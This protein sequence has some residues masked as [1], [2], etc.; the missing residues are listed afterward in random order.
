MS[1]PS[2]VELW[3]YL[4]GS[5]KLALSIPLDECRTF[6]L[7]PLKW[8]R[9]LGFVIYGRQGYISMSTNG[10][11]REVDPYTPRFFLTLLTFLG[12][13][14]F[15]DVDAI[16]NKTRS[17]STSEPSTRKRGFRQ[18][19]ISRDGTCAMIGVDAPFCE[20]CHLIPRSKGDS[21]M[22]NLFDHRGEMYGPV[23]PLDDIDD[24]RNGILLF[25]G[26]HRTLDAGYIAFL[27]T[28]NFALTID[29]IPCHQPSN[30]G[31]PNCLTLQ[32]IQPSQSVIAVLPSSCPHNTDARQPQ[33]TSQWPPTIIVDLA[34]AAAALQAWG[35]EAFIEDVQANSRDA[36]YDYAGDVEGDDS[37]DAPRDPTPQEPH[38]PTPPTI[39]YK[40]RSAAKGLAVNPADELTPERM[41]MY[42]VVFS[43]WVRSVKEARD[44][45]RV[46]GSGAADV[47]EKE[48]KV[49][50]W[51]QSMKR[52]TS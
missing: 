29:D 4:D 35:S 21:Y 13:P 15:V 17:T 51:L 45:R 11:E 5:S 2:K 42:D 48:N 38:Q 16:D 47:A 52:S 27:K 22:S 46:P 19:L 43:L 25:T 12:E 7:T 31:S 20:G 6:A 3:M 40:R 8:L 36:Y 30:A 23:D 39:R 33:D 49:E 18:A 34:Y 44:E 50:T 10:P 14:R 28:P 9:F 24:P 1:V 26:F 32:H 41:D 37:E